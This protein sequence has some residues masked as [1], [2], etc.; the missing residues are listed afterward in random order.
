MRNATTTPVRITTDP[1]AIRADDLVK[2]FRRPGSQDRLVAVDHV[3][4][5]IPAGQLVAFLGPNGAGKSTSIDMLLGLI[6]PDSGRVQVLGGDPGRAAR[7][8]RLAA[9]HQIGG[10][11]PDFTVAETMRAIAAIHGVGHRVDALLERWDLTDCA[12]TRVRKCSGGQ[13]QR[14]RF[15]LAMLPSPQILILDEPTAGL[16]VDA[17]RRFWRIM[18]AES[19]RGVTILFATHYIEEADSFADRV[20]LLDQGR[21]VADGTVGAVRGSATLED[22]FLRLTGKT[23]IADTDSQEIAS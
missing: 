4:F 22:A 14:L 10:L 15:A 23:G 1:P 17:R 6:R 3:S 21:I 13:Q 11:L 16:D 5:S 8:G 19:G 9:V 12:S 18:R 2:T 7:G 20:L